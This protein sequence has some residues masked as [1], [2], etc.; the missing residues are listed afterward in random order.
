MP[1]RLRDAQMQRVMM[2]AAMLAVEKRDVF[3][4][5]F[6][7]ALRMRSGHR[8]PFDA[9]VEIALQEALKG[10]RQESTV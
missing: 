7:S 5:R 3:L 4:R 8:M 9:D 2:A 6:A 10:L 1:M